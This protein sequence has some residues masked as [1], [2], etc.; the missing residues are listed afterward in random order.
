LGWFDDCFFDADVVVAVVSVSTVLV[1]GAADIMLLRCTRYGENCSGGRGRTWCGWSGW[2][3]DCF[4]DADVMFT[5]VTIATILVAGTA[6]V[7]LLGCPGGGENGHRGRRGTGSGRHD[8]RFL[9]ADIVFAVVSLA[10]VF[11]AGTSDV[12]LLGRS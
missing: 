5:V 6:N 12:V 11:I 7:M 9:L 1:A 2:Y 8:N 10:T 3:D 4:L